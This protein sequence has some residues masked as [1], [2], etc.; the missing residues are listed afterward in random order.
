MEQQKKMFDADQV[1]AELLRKVKEFGADLAGFAN[2]SDLKNGPSE[3]LFP[4]MKDHARDKYAEIITTG[5]EHGQVKWDDEEKCVLVYAL[6][7]PEEKPEMDW[8]Y[9]EINPPG[10]KLL[11][12][13]SKKMK[14]YIKENM[15]DVTFYSKPY[16]VERGGVYLKDA[17]VTAGIGCI[18]KNNLLVTP[19]FGPRVR[20]RA[21]GLSLDLPSTGATG[22]DPCKNC[23]APCRKACPQAAF[24]KSVYTS[25]ETGLQHLP[26]RDGFYYREICNHEMLENEETAP[27][28]LA[29][30]YSP[31]PL[32]II[33][34][35][36][37]CELNCV[38]GK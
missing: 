22:F 10:N 17:A 37:A 34:Y 25:E 5:L 19:E 21:I 12:Q 33:R 27:L 36:R 31:E 2:V 6:A 23:A 26:G 3:Q 30:E 7:H 28:E 35:C 1:Q 4:R 24:D 15:P 11:M 29:E 32:P 38:V 20:L 14:A 9:G 13:I 18:G 8:W 16:H